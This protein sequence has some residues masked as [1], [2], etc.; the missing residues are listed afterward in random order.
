MMKLMS[1]HKVL[2]PLGKVLILLFS[3]QLWVKSRAVWVL[4]P[5]LTSQS[6]KRKTLNA[7]LLNWA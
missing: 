6:R 5:W 4:Q 2:I 3:L 7:N 1:F